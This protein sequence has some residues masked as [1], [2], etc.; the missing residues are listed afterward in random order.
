MGQL[1]MY[2]IHVRPQLDHFTA[3]SACADAISCVL[4][5]QLG[6][7]VQVVQHN[8]VGRLQLCPLHLTAPHVVP[9]YFDAPG[10]RHSVKYVLHAAGNAVGG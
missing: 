6:G 2:N 3:T 4:H 8:L 9:S 7:A 10:A 1:S 5:S